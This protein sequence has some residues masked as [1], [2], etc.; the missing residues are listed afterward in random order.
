MT[1]A[2][3]QELRHGLYE[4]LWDDGSVSVAAVGSDAAGNRWFAPSNWLTVP[5]FKWEMVTEAHHVDLDSMKRHLD[6]IAADQRAVL[7]ILAECL[8]KLGAT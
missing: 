7:E 8:K 2:E 6:K 1:P 5:S 4:L 3:A